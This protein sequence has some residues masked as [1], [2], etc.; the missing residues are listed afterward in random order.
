M[1]ETTP[2]NPLEKPLPDN[3]SA[4]AS[5]TP[6]LDK[7]TPSS[8]PVPVLVNKPRENYPSV[9]WLVPIIAAA[10]GLWLVAQS[11]LSQG[12]MIYIS[13]IQPR[14]WKLVRQ[15]YAIKMLI[16]AR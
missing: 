8:D 15:K 6:S 16:S 3:A 2:E 9:I 11:I 12:P 10:I 1:H 14:V 13:L 5:E 4:V 7:T